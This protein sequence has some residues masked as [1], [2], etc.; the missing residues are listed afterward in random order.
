MSPIELSWTAKNLWYHIMGGVE[1]ES[2]TV[3]TKVVILA[4]DTLV[5]ENINSKAESHCFQS[6]LVRLRLQYSENLDAQIKLENVAPVRRDVTR[7]LT[8]IAHSFPPKDL[9]F[10]TQNIIHEKTKRITRPSILCV[11]Q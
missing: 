5:P 2:F 9:N 6:Y 7:L 11:T 1:L 4:G 8:I 10:H 3:A